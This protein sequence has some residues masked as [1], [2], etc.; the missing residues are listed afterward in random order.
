M[1]VMYLTLT[2]IDRNRKILC[3]FSSFAFIGTLKKHKPKL[4]DET[5]PITLNELLHIKAMKSD[6]WLTSNVLHFYTYTK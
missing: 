4:S 3:S 2:I 5:Y 6:H 1:S